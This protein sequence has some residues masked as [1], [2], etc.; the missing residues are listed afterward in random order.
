MADRPIIEQL[1]DFIEAIIAG[2]EVDFSAADPSI[3]ELVDICFK[4][5]GLPS[6]EF[7]ERVLNELIGKED[8]STPKMKM[9]P[10]QE[11]YPKVS[12]ALCYD[13]AA[14]AIEF[15]KKAFGAEETMRLVEPGGKV[16]HAELKIGDFM[17]MLSDEYPDY[18][19]VSP[20]TLGGSPVKLHLLVEDVDTFAAHAVSVGATIVRP[21][22]DQF[23]GHRTGHLKDPFGYTWVIGTFQ[24]EVPIEELQRGV[25]EFAAQEEAKRSDEKRA[26]FRREGFHTVTPYLSVERAPELLEFVKDVFGGTEIFRTTGSAGGMHAEVRVGDSMLM[27]GG[28]PGIEENPTAIHLYMPEV[29]SFYDRAVAA[30]STTIIAPSD[31][32]YGERSA[33][34]Q[35]PFGNFW[36]IATPFMPLEEIHKD[37]HTVGLYFHP[38]GAPKLIDFLKDAFNAE[39]VMRYASDQGYVYHAKLRI[40][41]S[42][43]EMGEARNPSQQRPYAI[44]MYVEDCDALYEQALRAGATS[45]MPPT[46]QPYGDRNA[47]VRDPFGNKWYLATTITG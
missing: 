28:G 24:K 39:E 23:Y 7:K 19:A 1:D 25:D 8:M 9:E 13:N 3:A 22:Q 41:D 45:E 17:I 34:I 27:I 46:D 44:Y 29:D 21:I 10:Q 16:G 42:I 15:Y 38:I 32:D 33:A 35:D 20:R 6:D 11:V 47:W 43:V 5:R 12:I 30:G 18:D 31:Q 37:L 2:R 14:A 36:Y 40:G 4:L 26:T